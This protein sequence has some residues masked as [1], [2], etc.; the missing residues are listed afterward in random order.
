MARSSF[1]WSTSGMLMTGFLHVMTRQLHWRWFGRGAPR[2]GGAG[3]ASLAA[4]SADAGASAAAAAAAC[5]WARASAAGTTS[6][7]GFT[8]CG[9]SGGG[10]L[11]TTGAQGTSGTVAR[12]AGSLE[13]G[14]ADVGAPDCCRAFD[15]AACSRVSSVCSAMLRRPCSFHAQ[16]VA[17]AILPSTN[18]WQAAL[19]LSAK[20]RHS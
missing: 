15:A 20:T 14:P 12:A 9:G 1:G 8:G 11:P 13:A 5:V 16:A 19:I 6:L 4:A 18:M 10:S 3:A 17:A 2:L 7:P